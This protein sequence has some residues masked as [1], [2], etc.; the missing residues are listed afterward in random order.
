MALGHG[1]DEIHQYAKGF[2]IPST[3]HKQG[4]EKCT[5][6]QKDTMIPKNIKINNMKQ[7]G[8]FSAKSAS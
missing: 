2:K 7:S 4:R 1:S 5:K 3:E 8:R 6:E